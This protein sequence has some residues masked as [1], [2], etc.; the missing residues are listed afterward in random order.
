MRRQRQGLGD[1]DRVV[2]A[3]TPFPE[4]GAV[5]VPISI[6]PAIVFRL[7]VRKIAIWLAGTSAELGVT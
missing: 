5:N 4:A 1:H 7:G 3:D 6:A 2:L